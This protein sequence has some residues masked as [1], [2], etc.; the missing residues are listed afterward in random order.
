M[1]TINNIRDRLKPNNY[2]FILYS[3]GVVNK[4]NHLIHS[5]T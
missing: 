5:L 4:L 3:F 2:D 1:N